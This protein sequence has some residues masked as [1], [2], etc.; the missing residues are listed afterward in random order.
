MSVLNTSVSGMLADSNW[1]STIAQNVSNA[2]TTGYKNTDTDFTA[3]LT[4]SG[5]T[6]QLAGV[7]TNTVSYNGLQGQVAST[8]TSTNLAVQGSGFFIVSNS[9]GDIFLTRNGSFVPDAEGNLV[10]SAGY[11]LMA[12]PTTPDNAASQ[13]V[14]S[15]TGLQKVNVDGQAASATPSTEATLTLNLNASDGVVAA[16]DLPSK[17]IAAS[18]YSSE[19]TITAYSDLGGA[20]NLDLYFTNEGGGKWEVDAYNAADA[21][22]GGGFPYTSGPLATT[23]LT[24]NT[25]TGD[26]ASTSATSLSIP[27]PSG[28]TMS[29]D[30][31]NATQ[32]DTSFAITSSTINGNAPGTVSG[33]TVA[34]NGI[35]S[36]DYTNGASA[37]AY[38]IPLANV[39]SVDNLTSV[40][41]QAYQVSDASG[42][43]QINNPQSAGMGEIESSSL[44]GSTVDL[45]T[46]LTN[47]IQAQSAYEANSK[48][49][50]T[51]TDLFDV[52]NNLKS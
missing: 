37:A 48:V 34:N 18:T 6:P 39:E 27:V 17:N 12:V 24:F 35:M 40:M 9:S 21:A 16:A 51:G 50:Q 45:A 36:F 8:Q 26:L 43:M 14:N 33:V 20:E 3:M 30:L 23:T 5:D 31:S 49:F 22:S 41:G 32:L 15:I 46:E 42:Q 47:M 25:S 29:L 19:T 38:I 13:T 1:L 28:Q 11:Y 7:A 52:L 10:N 4:A 2:N 44:E